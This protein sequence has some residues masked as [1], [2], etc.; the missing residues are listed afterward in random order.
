MSDNKVVQEQPNITNI[1]NVT[2]TNS[3]AV[4]HH[5]KVKAVYAIM[6]MV[7]QKFSSSGFW[8]LLLIAFGVWI[9]LKYSDRQ[10][11]NW[12]ETSTK[13]YCFQY[14]GISYEVRPRDGQPTTTENTSSSTSG[15]S[16]V[17]PTATTNKS[18][19]SKK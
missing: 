6:I 18:G 12:F 3:E 11:T 10:L 14:K 4:V 16:T 8:S 1:T 17:V 15:N 7:L 9:G 5:E 13:L 2:N 19:S